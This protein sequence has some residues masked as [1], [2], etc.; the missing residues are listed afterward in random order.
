MRKNLLVIA[1][2]LLVGCSQQKT[3][4][5]VE[6]NDS[7]EIERDAIDLVIPSR[8]SILED[9]YPMNDNGQTYG[10]NMGND[11]ITLGEPDLLLAEGENGVI[12]YISNRKYIFAK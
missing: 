3:L 2:I 7:S 12:G 10:P 1:V 5:K 11:T 9:G 6:D 8:E 4:P